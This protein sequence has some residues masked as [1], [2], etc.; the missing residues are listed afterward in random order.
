MS[1]GGTRLAEFHGASDPLLTAHTD[2]AIRIWSRSALGSGP[3]LK[4][5]HHTMAVEDVTASPFDANRFGSASKDGSWAVWDTAEAS[6]LASGTSASGEPIIQARWHPQLPQLLVAGV[7]D[8]RIELWDLGSSTRLPSL[9]PHAEGAL[10]SALALCP[11]DEDTVAAADEQGRL[12]VWDLRSPRKP[13]A[14][15]ASHMGA[16]TAL[17][18]AP[19]DPHTL[20]AA[21]ADGHVHLWHLEASAAPVILRSARTHTLGVT[22]LDWSVHQLVRV[23]VRLICG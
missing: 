18:F 7:L 1:V 21:G 23:R 8:G 9:A 2:P 10:L 17:S 19:H 22:A 20:A 3:V 6:P 4:L 11:Y 13:H 16:V 12:A 5:L 14:V 15:L